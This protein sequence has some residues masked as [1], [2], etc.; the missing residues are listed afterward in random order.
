[1]YLMYVDESG[2][3][4]LVGSPSRYFVLIGL[5][6]H[7]LRWQ[8]CLEQLVA[9]RRSMR[10]AFG[11]RLREE[12][13]AAALVNKPGPLVRIRRH[14]RLAMIRAFAD[15]LAQ[16]TDTSLINVVVDKSTKTCG[17]DVFA[18][19]W[20]ALIQRFENTISKRNFPGPANAD[21]RGLILCDHTEDR[22][23]MRLLRQMRKYNPVP[24][25]L[26]T[27]Y[28]NLPL[29]YVIEDPSF[30]DSEHSYF[31]QAVDLAAFLL[32]QHLK[33]NAYMR[34]HSGQNYFARL[35]PILCRVASP[36]DP[37]GI[38]RL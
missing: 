12:F 30:R 37:E 1:M 31:V 7:E 33:P 18:S 17:Y 5:V 11:L 36:K 26:A 25:Q 21:E 14:D 22:K 27:G 15:A 32:Y 38:V 29:L 10:G 23:L 9:F 19:A 16:M 24:S 6:I 35:V 3:T 4:G 28:R 13:H 8:S 20:K 2:D 34:S